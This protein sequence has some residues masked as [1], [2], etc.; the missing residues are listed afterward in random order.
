MLFW[1]LKDWARPFLIKSLGGYTKS[2]VEVTID[3]IS[4][5]Y[6]TIYYQHKR[7]LTEVDSL[8]DR[9]EINNYYYTTKEIV[10]NEKG[11]Q[12]EQV[13]SVYAPIVYSFENPVNDTLIEGKIFTI[14][15]P[16][17]KKIVKQTLDYKPKFPIFI[18]EYITI[19][20]T[21]KETLSNEERPKIG[22]GVVGNTDLY[23]GPIAV[24]QFKSGLQIQG[25]YEFDLNKSAIDRPKSIITIGIIKL[26]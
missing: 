5:K 2:D 9:K 22:I 4:K 24:Y 15:D 11:E 12:S 16:L 7:L 1:L 21:V 17:N 6:D 14:Y 10:T 23:T 26:F 13:K 3:T 20:K 19:Q 8:R 25:A 18:K